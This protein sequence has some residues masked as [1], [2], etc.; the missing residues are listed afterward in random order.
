MTRR[1]RI[2]IPETPMINLQHYSEVGVVKHSAGI[3][4]RYDVELIHT[5]TGIVKRKLSFPN[6][7]TDQFLRA[8][9]AGDRIDG[10]TSYIGVGTGSTAP[11]VSQTSLESEVARTDN[12]GGFSNESGSEGSEYHWFRRTRVFTESEANGNLTELGA[13]RSAASNAVMFNRQLFRDEFGEPTTITKTPEDQLRITYTYRVYPPMADTI[14]IVMFQGSPVEVITRTKS[15]TSTAAGGWLSLLTTLGSR[16][17]YTSN[18]RL[19]ES[20]DLHSRTSTNF[21]GVNA[22]SVSWQTQANQH[23]AEFEVIW[24]PDRA[25]FSAGVGSFCI[26]LNATVTGNRVP[27]FRSTFSQQILKTDTERFIL[28]GQIT[29]KRYEE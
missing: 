11:D 19:D 21:P 9:S 5:R 27:S 4:G 23:A 12:S 29:Y 25:N 2:W 16:N 8:I 20:S 3:S 28:Q 7:V 6:L 13:F 18:F 10:Y 24:G 17:E 26:S 1:K 22:S 15:A 14:D